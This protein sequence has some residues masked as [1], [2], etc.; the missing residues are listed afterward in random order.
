MEKAGFLFV[1]VRTSGHNP[2]TSGICS[3]SMWTEME[4]GH[5]KYSV[6]K[7]DSSVQETIGIGKKVYY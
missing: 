2:P 3:L 7:N 1:D 6:L 4:T 5:E